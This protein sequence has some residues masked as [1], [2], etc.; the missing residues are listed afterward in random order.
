MQI[1]IA[2]WYYNEQLFKVLNEVNK[3]FPVTVVSYFERVN[4]TLT[5][6]TDTER[7]PEKIKRVVNPTG[8]P[9]ISNPNGGLEWGNYDY[10][11]K[12][13]WDK[14]SNI[15]FM[16]DDIIIYN[17]SVFDIIKE[18]LS[19]WE[20]DQAFIF[21]DEAEE[22][23]NGRIHGRALY[24]SKRFI[25]FMLSYT[26]DCS[27][28]RDHEH[29]HYMGF[30]PKVILKGTGKHN[31]FWFDPFNLAEHVSGQPPKHCRHYNDGVYHFAEFAGRT[32]YSKPPW[33]GFSKEK[34]RGRVHFPEFNCGKRGQWI[35]EIYGRGENLDEVNNLSRN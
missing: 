25:D 9:V 19:R 14:K 5:R 33:P 31:G 12:N 4:G 17:A 10:Y 11:I 22:I 29:P 20:Y 34:V 3:T 28:S 6:D 35:G 23:S 24:C 18:K 16:H 7:I 27:Q 21:R 1:C 13:L 30:K 15:L 8:I 32:S 26:C 2:G